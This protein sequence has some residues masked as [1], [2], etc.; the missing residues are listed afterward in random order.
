MMMQPISYL[1]SFLI[2]EKGFVIDI[3]LQVLN[4]VWLFRNF[5]IYLLLPFSFLLVEINRVIIKFTPIDNFS[6]GYIITTKIV[7]DVFKLSLQFLTIKIQDSSVF[8]LMP[9]E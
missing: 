7:F 2:D 3:V 4:F 5:R 9:M 1:D 8:H 6:S